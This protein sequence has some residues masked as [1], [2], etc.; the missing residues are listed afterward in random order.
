MKSLHHVI[1]TFVALLVAVLFA[2]TVPTA[3]SAAVPP[4][5]ASRSAATAPA[6]TSTDDDSATVNCSST[7]E[8][9]TSKVV[10]DKGMN[11]FTVRQYIGWC[12]DSGG[13]AWMNFA[14]VYVWAQY[15]NLG[16]GYRAQAGI[17]V[18]GGGDTVGYTVGGNRQRLVYST[19]VRT[20]RSCT[21][22]W[23]K[24]LRGGAESAQGLTS[25]VC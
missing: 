22:G 11:A 18:G 19:P 21:Q 14:S 12:W 25:L 16:F 2:A 4:A 20:T 10:R 5:A 8:L 17:V 15:H 6:L 1:R 7:R 24:L 9:G 3:A 23:G 13:S